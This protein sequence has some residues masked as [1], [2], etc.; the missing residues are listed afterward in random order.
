MFNLMKWF[1]TV[2]HRGKEGEPAVLIPEMIPPTEQ[3]RSLIAGV[4]RK[5]TRQG[6]LW[7]WQPVYSWIEALDAVKRLPDH[8]L[9]I[10]EKEWLLGRFEPEMNRCVE[11]S[12]RSVGYFC[13][14]TAVSYP[15][16]YIAVRAGGFEVPILSPAELKWGGRMR[17][18][19]VRVLEQWLGSF[20][21]KPMISPNDTLRERMRAI[22]GGNISFLNVIFGFHYSAL[23]IT[24]VNEGQLGLKLGREKPG[25]L[26]NVLHE[27]VMAARQ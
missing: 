18:A 17:N 15:E 1:Q 24:V 27:P 10:D 11:E 7:R 9:T 26:F 3:E 6:E 13:H 19:R 21:G 25:I 8:G 14:V 20:E 5:L 4:V 2:F 16:G 12:K 22:V 23:D